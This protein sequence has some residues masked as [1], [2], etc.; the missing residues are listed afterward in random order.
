MTHDHV[1]NALI[2]MFV[3]SLVTLAQN[4]RTGYQLERMLEQK[5]SDDKTWNQQQG[6]LNRFTTADTAKGEV[7]SC[8]YPYVLKRTKGDK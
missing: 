1:R 4:L 6:W 3:L 7:E 5:E 2:I 8:A